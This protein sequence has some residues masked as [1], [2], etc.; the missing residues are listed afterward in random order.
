LTSSSSHVSFF[1]HFLWECSS[2]ALENVDFVS[3]TDDK[4]EFK[5]SANVPLTRTGFYDAICRAP[6]QAVRYVK[7]TI[8]TLVIVLTCWENVCLPTATS[9]VR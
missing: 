4:R 3:A 6:S 7:E 5:I 8:L 2:V 9:G 1:L